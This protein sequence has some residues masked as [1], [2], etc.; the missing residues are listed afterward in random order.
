MRSAP[1]DGFVPGPLPRADEHVEQILRRATGRRMAVLPRHDGA[2][3]PR[4]DADEPPPL[5]PDGRRL[6]W[7]LALTC[8]VAILSERDL[9]ELRRLVPVPEVVWAGSLGFDVGTP[10]RGLVSHPHALTFVPILDGAEA[11]LR[12]RIGG[13]P[14]AS[15]ARRRFS[16]LV[17]VAEAGRDARRPVEIMIDN[18]LWSAPECARPPRSTSWMA[19]RKSGSS[20]RRSPTRGVGP[21][22]AELSR[23]WPVPSVRPPRLA[24]RRGGV[25][26]PASA[27]PPLR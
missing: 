17:S 16:I 1:L 23:R 27:G 18:V 11:A 10:E 5:P 4:G 26:R 2:L 8:R 25:R 12:E 7:R 6:I 14:G 22:R 20:W 13:L 9:P 15:I 3:M 21:E 24:G 19:C